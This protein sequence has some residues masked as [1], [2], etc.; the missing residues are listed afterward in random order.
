[1]FCS[2]FVCNCKKSP[3]EPEAKDLVNTLWTLESFNIEGNI[4]RPPNDQLYTIQF[5]EDSTVSGRND[6]NNL[7][8]NYMISVDNYLKLEQLIRTEKGCDGDQAISNEY[9]KGLRE[10]K[11]HGIIENRLQIYYSTNTKL[12]FIK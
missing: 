5:K 2:L 12:N 7:Y 9:I 10:A 8:A 4:I 11:S 6:C 1:M 3:S